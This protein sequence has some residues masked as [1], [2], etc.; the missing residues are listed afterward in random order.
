MLTLNVCIIFFQETGKHKFLIDGFPR[1]KDNLDGWTRKMA[2][3][4]RLQF[5]LVFECSEEVCVDRCL[6][7]G[8]AGSG[9][10]DDNLESL[11]KRFQ[12]FFSDSL[13]IIEYYNTQNLVRKIDGIPEPDEVF[14]NVKLAFNEI[15]DSGDA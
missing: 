5:V 13:P 6:S 12:T 11:K 2:D 1:N 4:V 8:A 15:A 3:K 9:R 14:N 7:R 10:S